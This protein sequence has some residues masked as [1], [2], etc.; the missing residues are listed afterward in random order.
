V[1]VKM[2][3]VK[4]ALDPPAVAT[5]SRSSIKDGKVTLHGK[6]ISLG[7]ADKVEVGFEY[8]SYLGHHE[9]F[10]I[11]E[12]TAG[13]TKLLSEPGEFAITMPAPEA[14]SYSIRALVKHPKVTL[15][16]ENVRRTLK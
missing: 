10:H 7:D 2:T 1:T 15:R 13:P 14:G 5:L 11:N 12:W 8:Q 3:N 16:G 4:P 6:L 9:N